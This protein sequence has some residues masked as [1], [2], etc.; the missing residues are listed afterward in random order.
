MAGWSYYDAVEVPFDTP[1]ATRTYH[2]LGST[3]WLKMGIGMVT[4]GLRV[5]ARLE[6]EKL[7]LIK[8]SEI[9]K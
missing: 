8:P 7:S 9:H 2:I 3:E 5:K 4:K 1:Q 6:D